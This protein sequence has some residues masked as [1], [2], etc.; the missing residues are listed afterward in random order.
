MILQGVHWESQ[1]V[2]KHNVA[3]CVRLHPHIIAVYHNTNEL[4]TTMLAAVPVTW[5][6]EFPVKLGKGSVVTLMNVGTDLQNTLS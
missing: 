5:I 4:T 1:P 6:P 2:A 3:V